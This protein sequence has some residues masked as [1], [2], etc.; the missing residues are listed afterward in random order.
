[1]YI[2]IYDLT[3]G[4]ISPSKVS[5][6][7]QTKIKKIHWLRLLSEIIIKMQHDTINL[8]LLRFL[9]YIDK[10]TLLDTAST[11]SDNYAFL[12]IMKS[13]TRIQKDDTGY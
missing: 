12:N 10:R 8:P 2:H 11:I 6:E 4:T 9:S 7:Q 5:K 13:R 3:I 1:L